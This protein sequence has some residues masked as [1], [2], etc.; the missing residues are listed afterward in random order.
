MESNNV[1]QPGLQ[2]REIILAPP[3][4]NDLYSLACRLRDIDKRE[5]AAVTED[6]PYSNILYCSMQSDPCWV[7]IYYDDPVAI[8]G[9]APHL[10]REGFGIPWFMAT[11]EVDTNKAIRMWLAEHSKS[12]IA[13]LHERYRRLEN[14]ISAE[15]KTTMTWLEWLGF[16]IGEA[17]RLGRNGEMLRR[18]YREQC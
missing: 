10:E 8:G 4:P 15:N 18:I 2:G 9:A 12:L 16:Q 5:L 13:K 7:L 17:E 3:S 14:Y 11:D 6:D 1:I